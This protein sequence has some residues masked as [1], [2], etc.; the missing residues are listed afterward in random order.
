[1]TAERVRRQ[2]GLKNAPT[3]P[4]RNQPRHEQGDRQRYALDWPGPTARASPAGEEADGGGED[5]EQNHLGRRNGPSSSRARF[6]LRLYVRPSCASGGFLYTGRVRGRA[7]SRAACRL[8]V[9]RLPRD[10]GEPHEDGGEEH[11]ERG[12]DEKRLLRGSRRL[13]WAGDKRHQSAI[14]RHSCL[15]TLD[16]PGPFLAQLGELALEVLCAGRM[17]EPVARAGIL[18]AHPPRPFPSQV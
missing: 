4:R 9:W 3:A 2:S 14:T 10:D 16:E 15:A 7:P 8:V 12:Q 5:R 6:V 18:S 1:M 17:G 13:P 11:Q